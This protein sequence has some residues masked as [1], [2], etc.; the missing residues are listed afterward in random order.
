[1]N[2][3]TAESVVE[4]FLRAFSRM[5]LDGML[6]CLD[7]EATGFLPAEHE[8]TRLDGKEAIGRAFASVLTRVRAA[9]ATSLPLDAEDL[10]VQQWGETA[11]ATFQ[12]R[13]GHL[14]RR[15]LVLRR[16]AGR[17]RIVHLH[18]SNAPLEQ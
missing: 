13:A 2:G 15:T 6:D 5:D 17:W 1:M 18:A 10:L 9:G 16:Q 8:R 7:Q 11:V 3:N 4:T 14:S 12:L